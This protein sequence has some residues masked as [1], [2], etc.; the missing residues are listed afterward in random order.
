MNLAGYNH[1]IIEVVKFHEVDM[2][3][4]CNNAVYFNYFE[5][6]RL[7]YLYNMKQKHSFKEVMENNSF[8]MMAR[9]ECDYIEPTTLNDELIIYT[10]IYFIK[11]SSFG[12]KFIVVR[13]S[14]KKII[15]K[16]SDVMVHIDKQ[17]KKSVPLP[18]EFKKA[19]KEFEDEVEIQH[20][21]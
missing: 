13:A 19:V 5:D 15:A 17:T 16:G 3:G 21:N 14:D 20:S 2:L 12:F 4:V 11:K 8:F 6:A 18:D 10:K 7:K 1:N 9:N